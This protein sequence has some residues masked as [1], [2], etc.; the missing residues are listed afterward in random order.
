MK[1]GE[2]W[3]A[4]LPGPAKRRPVLLISRDEAYT[5]RKLVIIASIT[6]HI[7]GIA[8]EV[9]LGLDD[10]LPRVCAANFDTITTIPK[11]LLMERLSSLS[12]QKLKAAEIALHFALGLPK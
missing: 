5:V 6:T 9:P 10:G 2:I 8:S 7:R 11:A 4:E 3:W 1:R 12:P